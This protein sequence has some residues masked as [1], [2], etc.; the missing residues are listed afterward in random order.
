MMTTSPT[1]CALATGMMLSHK[2]RLGIEQVDEPRYGMSIARTMDAQPP[3]STAVMGW[4]G[5]RCRSIFDCNSGEY[6]RQVCGI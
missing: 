4:D 5:L 1:V 3:R 6:S 2:I